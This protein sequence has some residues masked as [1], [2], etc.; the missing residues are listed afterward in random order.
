V[1]GSTWSILLV[2]GDDG[3]VDDTK[4]LLGEHTV[5]GARNMSDGQ[6][7]L[8]EEGIEIAI[9]G[10]TFGS[11]SAVDEV[12]ALF[13]LRPALPV[14]LAT[15]ELTT[16]VLRTALRL[17]IKDVI[18]TPLTKDK[19]AES[20]DLVSQ[21]V[22]RGETPRDWRPRIGK[23]ITVM[24]PKG[25]AG[26]TVTASNVAVSLAEWSE[27]ERVAI[28][29]ADLQFGDVCIALQVDPKHTIVDAARDIEKLDA[30]LLGS[31]LARHPSGLRVLAAPLEPALADEVSTPVVIRTLGMLRRMFDYIIIDT[32]PFLD[33]P[34][35]SILERSDVVLLVVDMDLPSVKN[36]KLALD[37]L[38]LIKFPFEKIKLVLNRHN[39]KARLDVG[40]MERSLGLQVQ[41]SVVSDKLVPRAVNEGVPVVTLN[42]RS[43]VARDFRN[44]A[45]LVFDQDGQSGDDDRPRGRGRR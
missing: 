13:E 23:V 1:A 12:K 18:E 20:L 36:A 14:I 45:K 38:R 37:T 26:K 43:R 27:P 16:E 21:S 24:S 10:P 5:Y 6:R 31:L 3:F 29:D 22:S 40:E 34:V 11:S 30:E 41:A 28:F 32:A 42:P 9:L 17:G 8:V 33:E 39:S 4:G 19:L 7:R 44:V 2:D 35:L 25:G 15:D